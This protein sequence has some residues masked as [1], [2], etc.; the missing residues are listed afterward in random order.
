VY[1]LVFVVDGQFIS[2]SNNQVS[3]PHIIQ[4]PPLLNPPFSVVVRTA[5][6]QISSHVS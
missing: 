3:S 6:L 2:P 5:V 1:V 4:Q